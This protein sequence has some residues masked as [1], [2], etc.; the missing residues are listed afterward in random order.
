MHY[1]KA[2]L[3]ALEAAI[4]AER[5][6][7]TQYIAR[8]REQGATL[9]EIAGELDLTYARVQQIAADLMQEPGQD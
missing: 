4:A 2:R 3:K 6:A 7:R 9:Q 1:D 8:R 5:Q